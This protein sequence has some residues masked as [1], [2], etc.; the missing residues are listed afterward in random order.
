MKI[1][2]VLSLVLLISCSKGGSG[3]GG[4]TPTPAPQISITDLSLFEGNG[5]TTTFPVEVKL[6]NK[7]SKEVKVQY[8]TNEGFAKAGEDYTAVTNQTLTFAPNETTKTINITIVA[9]LIKEGDDDFTVQLS[10]PVNATISKADAKVIIR[11]DDTKISFT[12]T[13]YDAPTTYPGY[14]LD[15]ADEFNNTSLDASIWSNQ[16]GDGCPGNCGWG[17][18]EL[19]Y[20]T[21]RP[22]NI[23]FQDGKLVIEANKESFSGK[24]YTSSKILTSGK[25]KIKYGRIDIRAKLPTGQG[26]WPAFWMMPQDDVYGGWPASGEIDI[27]EMVGHEPNRTHGT[28]HYGTGWNDR[29]NIS[30]STTTSTGTLHDKFYVYSLEWKQDEIKWFLDGNLFATLTKADLGAYNY[31]FNEY[32]YLIFNLAVGGNWPGSPN[33]ATYFPQW[34]IVDYVRVY[35]PN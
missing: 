5:G 34:L 18:N 25:K 26:I 28:V 32:F 13:G 7:S 10:A 2:S 12:N 22:Q 20:Y 19:Q 4:E 16:N 29:K 27:M 35:K 23:F 6:S 9:D 11:N 15:W 21:N 30:K 1:L 24:S 33:A 14:T 8:S 17:N 3:G 31:P